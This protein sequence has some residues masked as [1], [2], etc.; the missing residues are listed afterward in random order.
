[1]IKGVLIVNNHGKTRLLKFYDNVSYD[2]QQQL[3]S[4]VYRV[5]SKRSDDLCNF[6]Q[7]PKWP[8]SD[9][10]LIYRHYA[11]LYFVFVVDD[12]ESEL[13]ILDL[14]QVFVETLD[15]CFEDVCELDLIFHSDRVHYILDEIIMG[16]MVL[17]TNKDEILRSLDALSQ[18]QK[19][20]KDKQQMQL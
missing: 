1:M 11:T 3:V 16:G 2:I 10:K 17:E 9:T 13:A 7:L 12:S 8:G 15:R 5:V 20:K 19:A 6:A 4:D 14:V 18:A